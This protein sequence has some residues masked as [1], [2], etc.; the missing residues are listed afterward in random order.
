MF[1]VDVKIMDI[2]FRTKHR[3]MTVTMVMIFFPV[4]LILT[5][6]LVVILTT[7]ISI[8]MMIFLTSITMIIS[9]ILLMVTTC[10]V[11]AIVFLVVVIKLDVNQVQVV[12]VDDANKMDLPIHHAPVVNA[13][14]KTRPTLLVSCTQYVL[15]L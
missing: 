13:V 7:M 3:R 4:F 9:I 12:Q 15:L 6:I 2:V 11:F 8:S 10:L 1:V 5:T 14:N